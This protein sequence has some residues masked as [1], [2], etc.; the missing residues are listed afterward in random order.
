M[1]KQFQDELNEAYERSLDLAVSI[2][3]NIKKGRDHSLISQIKRNYLEFKGLQIKHVPTTNKIIEKKIFKSIGQASDI[4]NNFSKSEAKAFMNK[5]IE[6]SNLNIKFSRAGKG[7]LRYAENYPNEILNLNNSSEINNKPLPHVSLINGKIEMPLNLPYYK[8]YVLKSNEKEEEKIPVMD[9]IERCEESI[10][11]FYKSLG[12]LELFC[13][14]NPG[15]PWNNDKKILH[16]LYENPNNKASIIRGYNETL[17]GNKFRGRSTNTRFSMVH[18]KKNSVSKS[19]IDSSPVGVKASTPVPPFHLDFELAAI[20]ETRP[21][22]VTPSFDEPEDILK[23]VSERFVKTKNE[24]NIKLI[25]IFKKVK[26]NR[27]WYLKQKGLLIMKDEDNYK[28]KL[29]TLRKFKNI[30]RKVNSRQE[31]RLKKNKSQAKIYIKLLEYLSNKDNPTEFQVSFSNLVRHILE[32]G[33][34]LTKE[35]I[36]S[37]SL[38]LTCEESNDISEMIS[39]INNYDQANS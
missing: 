15:I 4:L 3:K 35:L 37:I 2:S 21:I 30:S 16:K 8:D 26:K 9:K 33:W 29:Y 32:E 39:I 36:S 11:E 6:E 19:S 22:T 25:N 27:P 1:S 20:H 17:Y 5:S 18:G 14:S 12:G 38:N 28:N 7:S 34:I 10:K 31:K 24:E 13:S 23:R